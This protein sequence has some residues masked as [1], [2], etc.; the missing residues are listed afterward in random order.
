MLLDKSTKA[1]KVLD[2]YQKRKN[3]GPLSCKTGRRVQVCM[4]QCCWTN[5]LGILCSEWLLYAQGQHW[6]ICTFQK[7]IQGVRLTRIIHLT[8]ASL[9]GT[10]FPNLPGYAEWRL[11]SIKEKIISHA[12]V[13]SL[14]DLVGAVI[15]ATR[16]EDHPP[17]LKIALS[18]TKLTS[19]DSTTSLVLKTYP[20]CSRNAW[21]ENHRG[22]HWVLRIK[23]LKLGKEMWTMKYFTRG[24][25]I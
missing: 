8:D 23:L 5:S 21:K 18:V 4:Q 20:N 10:W 15:I 11:C 17:G 9:S 7:G 2:S 1:I 19:W 22:F 24:L 25:I 16:C 14:L 13:C 3:A 12:A 6:Y